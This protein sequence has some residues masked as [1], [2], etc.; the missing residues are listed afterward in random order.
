[1]TTNCTT[2]GTID[3]S[4]YFLVDNQYVCE[5]CYKTPVKDRKSNQ[6]QHLPL[7]ERWICLT[8]NCGSYNFN[9]KGR[10][11]IESCNIITEV[12]VGI[13]K[14][15]T[16]GGYNGNVSRHYLPEWQEAARRNDLEKHALTKWN[17]YISAI[18]PPQIIENKKFSRR[19]N[20]NSNRFR[21]MGKF[22]KR[23][24]KKR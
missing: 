6:K 18:R 23:S 1:M 19:V 8:H 4:K 9:M 22:T 12:T 2:C 5:G 17:K 11:E 15:K 14:P 21:T 3:A 7:F 10:H 24:N 16:F 20:R 13:I